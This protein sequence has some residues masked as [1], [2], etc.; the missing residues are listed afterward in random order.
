MF[1][2]EQKQ[3]GRSNL[4]SFSSSLRAP[5]VMSTISGW[6]RAFLAFHPALLSHY[7]HYYL[8]PSNPLCR[9]HTVPNR[10]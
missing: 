9:F 1:T 2:R 3:K 4:S 10:P 5:R 6:P 7:Y 8:V